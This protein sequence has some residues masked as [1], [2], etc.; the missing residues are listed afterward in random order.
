MSATHMKNTTMKA[1]IMAV[2]LIA[3]L[4]AFG[5]EISDYH[6]KHA[7]DKLGDHRKSRSHD[8]VASTNHGIT[9]IG[10]ERTGCFGTCPSYTFIV[11][12][13]GTFRYKGFDH[14]ER[15]GEF[16][17]T[18]SAWY[19]HPLAQFIRDSS[20]MELEDGYT[21]LDTDNPTTYTMV[22]M[23]GKR[24]TVSNYAHAGPTKLWAIEQLIDDLMAKAKWDGPQKTPA[25]KW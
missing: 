3:S 6:F 7:G 15:K 25:K 21:G 2:I 22:V 19:F 9:E 20:Y 1:L 23:N 14:V 16:S 10:I 13:D 8:E 11:K 5:G 4:L 17:G 12:S 24:K 18:I